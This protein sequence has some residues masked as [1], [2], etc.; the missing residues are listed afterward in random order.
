MWFV[1]NALTSG[2][3]NW[4]TFGTEKW[5][6]F[7]KKGFL[8]V[9]QQYQKPVDAALGTSQR[10]EVPTHI[11]RIVEE[12]Q[13]IVQLGNQSGE[14]WYLVG[15]M[16]DMIEEGVPNI[17]VV[18]PFACLPNH[19]TGRGIFREIRRQ[20]PHANVASI[21]Y[22]PGA[23]QVNQLNRIKLMAATARDRHEEL[24]NVEQGA[25]IRGEHV[26]GGGSAT[27]G[28][29]AA[30]GTPGGDQDGSE[31]AGMAGAVDLKDARGAVS[32]GVM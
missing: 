32:L 28:P 12:A 18:Q 20:Y 13:Q 25:P 30:S 8:A 29:G 27:N 11:S 4:K 23:S 15:E 5:K 24:T 22:D 1:H 21:D 6:R 31:H 19:V 16:I 9:L 26:A 7:L 14:G 17:C 10:F 3:Y 2:D